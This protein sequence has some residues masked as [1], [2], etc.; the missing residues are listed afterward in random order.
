MTATRKR[1]DRYV[2]PHQNNP[3]SDRADIGKPLKQNLMR[4][5]MWYEFE[6]TVLNI[7]TE[8]SM[9]IYDTQSPVPLSSC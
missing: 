3:W 1:G 2:G 5:L 9:K 4:P 6:T 8:D 7:N